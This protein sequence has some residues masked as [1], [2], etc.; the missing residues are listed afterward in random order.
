MVVGVGVLDAEWE[1]D[2]GS[3]DKRGY[4]NIYISSF[5][6]PLS[7][8]ARTLIPNSDNR[9]AENRS[10]NKCHVDGEPPPFSP[11][12][13]HHPSKSASYQIPDTKKKKSRATYTRG[14]EEEEDEK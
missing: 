9:K 7:L 14:E 3:L 6:N 13:H 5:F 12:P 4:S 11:A 10:E 8:A 2:G 1:G